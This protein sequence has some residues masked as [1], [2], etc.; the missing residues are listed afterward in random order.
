MFDVNYR[1]PKKLWSDLKNGIKWKKRSKICCFFCLQRCIKSFADKGKVFFFKWKH[2]FKA[3]QR[4]FYFYALFF[5]FMVAVSWKGVFALKSFFEK[6][7]ERDSI[8]GKTERVK[9]GWMWEKERVCEC[10]RGCVCM[11]DR[12]RFRWVIW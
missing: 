4:N 7:W 5:F 11:C 6:E 12:E 2:F 3:K 8:K 1:R 10:E 9:K